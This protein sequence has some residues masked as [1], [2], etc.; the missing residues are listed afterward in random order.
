MT[1][2]AEQPGKNSRSQDSCLRTV[3]AGQTSQRWHDS[4]YS[5][6]HEQLWQ[7][8]PRSQ[9]RTT[10]TAM[11]EQARRAGTGTA[12]SISVP[13][14]SR[15]HMNKMNT[16]FLL[17]VWFIR[18]EKIWL[19]LIVRLSLI[20]SKVVSMYICSIRL[21]ALMGNDVKYLLVSLQSASSHGIWLTPKH[22]TL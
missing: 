16:T 19:E 14:D 2:V 11:K 6:E 21:I 3:R 4:P 5:L 7:D 20:Y 18:L 10:S 15:Q 1:A 12:L 8:N 22:L 17:S 13:P 9:G